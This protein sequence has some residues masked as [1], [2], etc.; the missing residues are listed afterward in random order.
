MG[1]G[2]VCCSVGVVSGGLQPKWYR[3]TLVVMF[4]VEMG[5]AT[6]LREESGTLPDTLGT[7]RHQLSCVA[8]VHLVNPNRCYLYSM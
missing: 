7:S 8:R 4:R 2:V 6:S 3:D 1:E 5:R